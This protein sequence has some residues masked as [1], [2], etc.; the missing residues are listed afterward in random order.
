MSNLDKVV[1]DFMVLLSYMRTYYFR[2][3]EHFTRMRFGHSHMHA[4]SLIAK[5]GSCTM[6]ELAAEL[7]VS[8]QQLTRLVDRMVEAGQVVRKPDEND[9]RLVRIELSD[10]GRSMFKE[11]GAGLKNN[12]REKLSKIP[13]SE[14]DELEEMLPRIHKILQNANGGRLNCREKP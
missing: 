11:M 8:K 13:D 3:A 10:K 2:P 6:R 14:L 9:R 7:M 5:R 12:F 1:D 4:L